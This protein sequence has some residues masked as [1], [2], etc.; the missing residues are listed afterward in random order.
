M[1]G[2]LVLRWED[3]GGGGRW[4]SVV[5]VD[6]QGVYVWQGGRQVDAVEFLR[7]RGVD[8]LDADVL[9]FSALSR[10]ERDNWT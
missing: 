5:R 2:P 4:R 6:E 1:S 7:S 3:R 9:P 10:F 8:P